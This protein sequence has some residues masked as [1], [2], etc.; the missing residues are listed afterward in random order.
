M[1]FKGQ[2]VET[3]GDIVLLRKPDFVGTR[4]FISSLFDNYMGCEA[5]PAKCD[6]TILDS[7]RHPGDFA[8]VSFKKAW[9][10]K[11]PS[12]KTMRYMGVTP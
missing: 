1:K 10:E 3:N 8:C 9:L 7:H 5:C 12:R 11:K 4:Q 2:N 6:C